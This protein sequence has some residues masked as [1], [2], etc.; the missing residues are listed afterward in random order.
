VAN[1]AGVPF[2]VVK[3]ADL[4]SK[5]FAKQFAEKLQIKQQHVSSKMPLIAQAD[6]VYLFKLSTISIPC[7]VSLE[8][9]IGKYI[10]LFSTRATKH[11]AIDKMLG[12]TDVEAVLRF[13][14]PYHFP[15][16]G[17]WTGGPATPWFLTGIRLEG[18]HVSH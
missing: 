8:S 7:S 4:I 13:K 3:R 11:E 14:N 15:D 5:D 6:F 10:E 18:V 12:D 17:W 1:I 9:F 2:E 16:L